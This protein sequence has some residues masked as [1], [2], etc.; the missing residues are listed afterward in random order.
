MKRLSLGRG[1]LVLLGAIIPAANLAAQ[2]VPLQSMVV[3]ASRVEEARQNVPFSV[4]VIAGDALRDSPATTLD[5]AL[6]SAPAFSLFRRS[7]SLTANPTAQGVSLRG[8]GPSG[9]SRSLVLLDGIPLNDPFGGW[10]AWT[11]VPRESLARVELVPGGGATV[12]GNA[13][14]GGVVHLLTTKPEGN[15]ERLAAVAGD[16][17][18]RSLEAAVSRRVGTGVVELSGRDF[19]TQGFRTVG[20]ERRGP[21]DTPAGNHHSWLSGR[22]VQP[23]GEK[24]ELSLT[25]RHFEETRANGTPYQRNASREDFGALSLSAGRGDPFSWEASAYL[26]GQ[27][28]SST[29]SSVNVTRTA[30]TPASDQFSVPA[31]ASGGAW[32]GHWSDGRG[33][34][35]LGADARQVR[36]ETRERFSFSGGD[37][38]RERMAG[39][40]QKIGG[41]FLTHERTV[42]EKINLSLGVRADGWRE[43]NGHRRETDRAS[44]AI[45][46]DDAI[47]SRSGR[48]FSPSAGL[49]WR[50]N[51]TLRWRVAGQRAFRRPTLNELYRPFRAGSVITEANPALRSETITSAEIGGEFVRRGLKLGATLFWNELHDAVANITVAKG[52]ITLPEFGFIPAGGAGRRRLNLE[53]VEVRGAEVTGEWSASATLTFAADYQWDDARVRRASVAP[54]LEGLRVAQVPRHNASVGA[55]WCASSRLKVTPRVRWLSAQF[56]DDENLLEL[57]PVFVGDLALAYELAEG[58]EIFVAAENV[59]NARIETGRSADGVVN[60]GTPRLVSAGVRLK[61]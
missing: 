21:I 56:E 31:T 26:Q 58:R 1:A 48:E 51:E 2:V 14:L 7:D 19:M 46:R 9:A 15:S 54:A 11:K 42:L 3:T 36:G 32:A 55:V 18:T 37:F 38:T 22:W 20:A 6:R 44:G 34:T 47:G 16:Y 24:A 25:G 10:V 39:G 49:V 5:A 12:W 53:R 52:P 59:G 17:E 60:T 35:T 13:A 43:S 29:F 50:P 27:S 4:N 33:Q 45:L 40:V 30:E 57:A 41:L 28:F 61:W 8:I 23:I